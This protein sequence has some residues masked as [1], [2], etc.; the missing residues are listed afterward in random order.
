MFRGLEYGLGEA[1]HGKRVLNSRQSEP[2]E[3]ASVS[4]RFADAWTIRQRERF[5]GRPSG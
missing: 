2:E 4:V 3:D 5:F 1:R